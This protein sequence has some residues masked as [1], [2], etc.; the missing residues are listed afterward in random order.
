MR[1]RSLTALGGVLAAAA[2]LTLAACGSGSGSSATSSSAASPSSGGSSAA[3]PAGVAYAQA[4]LDKVTGPVSSFTPPG[5]ALTGDVASLSGKTVY[6]VPATSAVPLFAAIGGSLT[7]ALATVGVKVQTCDGKSNPSA[8]ADCLNQAINTKAAAVITGSIPAEFAPT[9]FKAVSDAGIPLVNTLTVPAGPD[10]PSKV[11]Y[12]TPNFI[13][14]QALVADSII[15]ASGGKAHV[16]LFQITDNPA[17]QMWVDA[18]ALPEYQKQCP[19]CVV[20]VEK[21]NTGQISKIPSIVSA[22]LIKDPEITYVHSEADSLVQGIVT[23]LQS[24]P[25]GSKVQIASMDGVLQVLQAVQA[26]RGVM[27]D[28]GYNLN[29][30]GWYT[31]DQALRL[32]TGGSAVQNLEFP[33]ARSFNKENTADLSLTPE[34]QQTGEWYGSTDYQAGFKTLWG[35]SS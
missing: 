26:G 23:G 8:I 3:A 4:Q 10:D 2:S 6:W 5:P 9:A 1:H 11:A 20:T 12:I 28:M 14:Y 24:S 25:N 17:V 7:E 21:I 16:L 33:Y 19:D 35:V 15:A 13:A 18:G 27:S 34:A 32:M 31:A 30:F 22:A 29:A